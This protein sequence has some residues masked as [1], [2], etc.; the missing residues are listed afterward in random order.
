M[1]E[2]IKLPSDHPF[3]QFDFSE[4]R[5]YIRAFTAIRDLSLVDGEATTSFVDKIGNSVFMGL[6]PM[7]ILGAEFVGRSVVK[8][9]VESLT[10]SMVSH[11]ISDVVHRESINTRDELVVYRDN[12]IDWNTIARYIDLFVYKLFFLKLSILDEELKMS[13]R[14]EQRGKWVDP[15]GKERYNMEGVIIPFN[16]PVLLK[17]CNEMASKTN[18]EY[19]NNML[20]SYIYSQFAYWAFNANYD[21][22]GRLLSNLNKN[23]K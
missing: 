5:D 8:D 16:K 9:S 2:L 14:V 13:L 18:N 20:K 17:T 22:T 7:S 12:E 3:L 19:S 11:F 15:D 23:G 1:S 6:L 21:A 4:D 10:S